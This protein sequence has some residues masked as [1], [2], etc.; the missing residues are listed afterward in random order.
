[1]RTGE[2]ERKKRGDIKRT[3]KASQGSIPRGGHLREGIQRK[4]EQKRMQ[5]KMPGKTRDKK[6]IRGRGESDENLIIKAIRRSKAFRY[7]LEQHLRRRKGRV[8]AGE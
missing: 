2:I 7:H 5:D 6:K 8:H 1:M 4:R 3:S